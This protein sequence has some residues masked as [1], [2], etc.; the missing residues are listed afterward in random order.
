MEKKFSVKEFFKS[1]AFK[2][3]YVLLAIVLVC[4]VLLAFCNDLF[5]VTAKRS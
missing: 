4:G 1:T 3:I 2:C 5:E